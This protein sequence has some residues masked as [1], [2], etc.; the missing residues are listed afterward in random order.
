MP[1]LT[2]LS[3]PFRAAILLG[4]AV[5]GAL[6]VHAAVAWSA[7]RLVADSAGR[8]A[9]LLRHGR[10]PLRAVLVV[11]AT[12]IV[13]PLLGL[14]PGVEGS[15][16]HIFLVGLIITISWLL[17]GLANAVQG[18]VE[19]RFRTDTRDN[20]RARRV[21]TKIQ[22]LRRVTTMV[23]AFLAAAAI[24]VTFPG[25][26]EVGVSLLASAGVVG[27]I[28]GIAARSTLSNLLAGLQV[29]FSE[30][31]RL[32]DVVIV[33]GEWG[34]IEEIRTTYV[35]VRLWDLRRLIVPL[36]HFIERPFQNW[37]RQSAD[38]LG[39]VH[40][41]ADYRVPVDE[42]RTEL[43]HILRDT[44]LWDG[45]TWNLQVV[46]AG[47]RTI[48]LRALMSAPDAPTAWNLRCHVREKLLDFLRREHPDSLP[49]TRAELKE[50]ESAAAFAG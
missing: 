4:G 49:R 18:I 37:T 1:E 3:G 30:P 15:V 14:P 41:H 24:L 7:G 10:A 42:V 50:G 13:I 34:R 2:A 21:H 33:E 23:V 32:D 39:A 20:L 11:A 12:Y 45:E 8:D 19:R 22:L 48:E 29:A 31:I 26:R 5:A 25:V 38:I 28:L 40:L 6:V 16:R 27:I 46:G 9:A 44:E 36:S 43:E 35:V 47:E 17:L